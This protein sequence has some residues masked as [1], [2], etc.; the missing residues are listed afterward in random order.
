M[1]SLT[2]PMEN[3]DTCDICGVHVDV[4][5]TGAVRMKRNAPETATGSDG[6][7]TT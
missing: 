3:C 7:P 1:A 6:K 4:R 2:A 5:K